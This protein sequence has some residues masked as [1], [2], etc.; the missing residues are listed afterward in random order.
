MEHL[1][2]KINLTQHEGA[3]KYELEVGQEELMSMGAS[4]WEI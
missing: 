4:F 2:F 3:S 1:V